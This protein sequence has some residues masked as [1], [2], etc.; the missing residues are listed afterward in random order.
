MSH[1]LTHASGAGSRRSS[2]L[3]CAL[4]LLGA[5]PAGAVELSTDVTVN[6]GGVVAADEAVVADIGGTAV[7]VDLGALPRGA[8][9]IAFA[10][11]ANGDALFTLD[12]A[13]ALP[14]GAFATPRDVVRW[15]GAVHAIE[16]RGADR[17]IPVGARIDAIAVSEGD[18]L[19]SFDVTVTLGGVTA[20]DEDLLR[21]DGTQ[22]DVW[23]LAFDGSAH[24]IARGADLDAADAIPGGPLA[25]SFDVSGSIGGIPFAD[26]DVLAFAPANGGW[27]KRYD[28]SARHAALA[29]GDVDAVAVPEPLGAGLAAAAALVL[30]RTRRSTRSSDVELRRSVARDTQ[31]RP[32]RSP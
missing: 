25:L 27:S 26:E 17:G 4:A 6:V 20:A 1:A 32:R 28:G 31:R 19:L 3:G 10:R 7:R 22:P 15:D 30:L 2:L 12:T 21:L 5:G 24:G 8:D 29:A 18:L 9:L 11:A 13:V 16:L 23:S 14:G